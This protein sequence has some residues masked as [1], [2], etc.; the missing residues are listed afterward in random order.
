M[1]NAIKF[2]APLKLQPSRLRR[3]QLPACLMAFFEG[4]LFNGGIFEAEWAAINPNFVFTNNT[5]KAGVTGSVHSE[6]RWLASVYDFN[7]DW[8]DA[9]NENVSGSALTARTIRTAVQDLHKH[10]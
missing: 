5:T 6:Y 7:V 8:G 3:L 4:G 10:D 9:S 2:T 1:I